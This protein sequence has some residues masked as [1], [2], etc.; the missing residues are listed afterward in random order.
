M[1]SHS[2][3]QAISTSLGK[4]VLRISFGSRTAGCIAA[5]LGRSRAATADYY[6]A[7]RSC[8]PLIY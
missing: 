7:R 8:S 1:F 2:C 3:R 5:V 4:F 6:T